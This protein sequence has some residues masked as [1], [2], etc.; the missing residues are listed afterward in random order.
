MI[1]IVEGL[2]ITVIGMGVVFLVLFLLILVLQ[3]FKTFLYKEKDKGGVKNPEI[4]R[5]NS[6]KTGVQQDE[7]EE[8]VAV[9]TAVMEDILDKNEYISKIH[10]MN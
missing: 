1:N 4:S 10:Q 6:L 2:T 9:V 7:L 3:L 5:Q 8:I